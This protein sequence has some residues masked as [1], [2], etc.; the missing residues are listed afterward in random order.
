MKENY[1]RGQPLLN[2]IAA[3]IQKSGK[4]PSLST[5]MDV[6]FNHILFHLHTDGKKAILTFKSWREAIAFFRQ[7]KRFVSSAPS[8]IS[9]I[10]HFLHTI[11]LTVY[12]QNKNRKLGVVGPE[13]G[14]LV[15][16]FLSMVSFFSRK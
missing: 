6:E 1:D 7:I 13:A 5:A 3:H 12:L 10:R 16:G 9:D 8:A 14:M 4:T 15:P 11:G 2:T